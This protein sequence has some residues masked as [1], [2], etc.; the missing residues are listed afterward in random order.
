MFSSLF[1][2]DS[3]FLFNWSIMWIF[4]LTPPWSYW[5]VLY[6][7]G[8]LVC[9]GIKLFGMEVS[10]ALDFY[11][12]FDLE[13]NFDRLP[14]FFKDLLLSL[15]SLLFL[16]WILNSFELHLAFFF[17]LSL[18]FS[19]SKRSLSL[20]NYETFSWLLLMDEFL[21]CFIRLLKLLLLSASMLVDRE[22]LL[23]ICLYLKVSI[24]SDFYIFTKMDLLILF[25]FSLLLFLRLPTL[26]RLETLIYGISSLKEFFFSYFYLTD[27]FN[28][29]NLSN[30]FFFTFFIP[31][32]SFNPFFKLLLL[33]LLLLLFDFFVFFLSFF[34]SSFFY[35]LSHFFSTSLY[36]FYLSNF[37]FKIWTCLVFWLFCWLLAGPFPYSFPCISSIGLICFT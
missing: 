27:V 6:P 4:Y 33:L 28:D 35:S 31:L 37:S 29:F 14:S 21:C 13:P 34:T 2:V 3:I 22:M 9:S 26:P 7:M 5:L 10:F 23:R 32:Y 30:Y 17:R 8:F 24:F 25:F 36:I 20:A 19:F 11:L 15:Y 16:C 12:D 18:K 1:L